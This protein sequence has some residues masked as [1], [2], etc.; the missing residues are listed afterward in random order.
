MLPVELHKRP[1][2]KRTAMTLG[3]TVI[4]HNNTDIPEK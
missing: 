2:W 1:K 4:F 3:K